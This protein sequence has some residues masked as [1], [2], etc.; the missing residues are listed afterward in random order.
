LEF[1]VDGLEVTH[2]TGAGGLAALGLFAPVELSGLSSRVAAV[3]TGALLDVERTLSASSAE[4]VRLV[5]TLTKAGGTLRCRNLSV[6]YLSA[7][8]YLSVGVERRGKV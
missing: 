2:A 3:G 8:F 7:W 4:R 6:L 1:A 5:V